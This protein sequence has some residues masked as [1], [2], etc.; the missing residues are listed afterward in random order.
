MT[1]TMI[2]LEKLDGEVM[3]LVE[4]ETLARSARVPVILRCL[5]DTLDDVATVIVDS[6]GAVRNRLNI[7][8]GLSAWL[9]LSAV[10]TLADR[11]EVRQINLDFQCQVA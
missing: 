9:P 3:R 11:G 2:H 10:P 6:G 7:I 8:A 5:P 4:D 1:P